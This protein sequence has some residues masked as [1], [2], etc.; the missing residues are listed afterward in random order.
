MVDLVERLNVLLYQDQRYY[1]TQDYLSPIFQ[2]NL[3]L[4]VK[5][6]RS[7][8]A[9]ST[10]SA[11]PS[12]SINE[13]WREKICEWSYQVVDHFDFSRE[14]VSISMSFLDRF[15]S[16]T[17]D[18]V[19]KKFFQLTAMT[20][21]YLAVK[22]YEP[23]TLPMQAMIELS[24]GYFTVEQMTAMEME[25]LRILSW[26]VHPPTPVCFARH[27]LQ[28][29]PPELDDTAKYDVM[30]LARFLTELAVIEY[31]FVPKSMSSLALGAVLHALDILNLNQHIPQLFEQLELVQ[32]FN[33]N[34]VEVNECRLRL[35][36]MY[37]QGGYSRAQT[38]MQ[39]EDNRTESMASP[40]C[41]SGLHSTTTT[42]K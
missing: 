34:A 2:A 15:L 42:Y 28:L 3:K 11:S 14:V 5:D 37:L 41:V 17:R 29:I 26:H 4:P 23:G 32:Q 13:A 6:C 18:L 36:D 10:I 19:D 8:D 25:I 21:L 22:L 38:V 39:D 9:V 16:S 33:L 27:F 31:F 30:E 40:I 12:V 20:C 1:K 35:R 7:R 24:R